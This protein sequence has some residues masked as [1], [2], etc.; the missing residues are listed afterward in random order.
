MGV[1]ELVQGTCAATPLSWGPPAPCL[2]E[3]GSTELSCVRTQGMGGV[4]GQLSWEA[5][6]RGT[7]GA[8]GFPAVKVGLFGA[9]LPKVWAGKGQEQGFLSAFCFS[10]K[11][12]FGLSLQ[13]GW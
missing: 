9:F 2:R 4:P 11:F 8:A 5:V 7:W 3:L 1:A 12:A 13:T 6:C 10:S